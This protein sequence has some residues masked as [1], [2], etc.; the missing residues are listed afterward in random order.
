MV[1]IPDEFFEWQISNRRKNIEHMLHS[2]EPSLWEKLGLYLVDKVHHIFGLEKPKQER[3]SAEMLDLHDPIIATME[4]RSYRMN[5]ASK[6]VGLVLATEGA[7]REFTEKA[8]ELIERTY[9]TSSRETIDERLQ[10]LLDYIYPELDL[11]GD[12]KE[13]YRLDSLGTLEIYGGRTYMNIISTLSTAHASVMYN[14]LKPGGGYFSQQF[15]A[16]VTVHPR[17][18]AFYEYFVALHDLFHIPPEKTRKT[19]KGRFWCAYEFRV[20]EVYD[21]APGPKAGRKIA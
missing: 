21:K 15:N 5:L 6:G 19:R 4:P 13:N 2:K 16:E 20:T 12:W 14:A 10:L 17:G 1:D 8:D 18:S 9:E 7:M 11:E 3:M